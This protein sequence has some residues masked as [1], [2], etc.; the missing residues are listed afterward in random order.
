M[1]VSVSRLRSMGLAKESTRGT[2]VTTP[3][4]YINGIPPDSFTP[5]IEPLPSKGIEALR[6]MYPKIT[7]GPATLNGMKI[8]LEVEPDNIGEILQAIFGADSY[9]AAGN[10][11]IILSGIND[12]ID[13]TVSAVAYTAY[14]PNG[15]YTSS[16]L[17]TA[18]ATAMN[19]VDNIT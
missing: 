9:T 4:R 17:E 8:K 1:S 14:V 7:Q 16:T 3:T 2:E 11:F 6:N 12:A 18:I 13:F 10:N 5:S 15:V 19:A